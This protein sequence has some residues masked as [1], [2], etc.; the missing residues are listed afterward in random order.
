VYEPRESA[1]SATFDPRRPPLEDAA[2]SVPREGVD[3]RLG[4]LDMHRE[5][6]VRESVARHPSSDQQPSRAH[7]RVEH[8]IVRGR[9]D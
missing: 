5:A 6:R 7:A 9:R 4:L 8:A 3:D 2:L 1:C